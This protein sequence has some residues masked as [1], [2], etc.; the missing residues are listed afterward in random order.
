MDPKRQ[1]YRTDLAKSILLTVMGTGNGP[2]A[3]TPQ[4]PSTYSTMLVDYSL[5]LADYFMA[6][7]YDNDE[8]D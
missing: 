2:L 6:K 4:G 3:Q 7:V 1:Q 5:M 8:E